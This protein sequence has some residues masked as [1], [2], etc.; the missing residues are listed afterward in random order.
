M[1]LIRIPIKTLVSLENPT[2]YHWLMLNS[3]TITNLPQ[4]KI[5]TKFISVDTS[6]PE[7]PA[8]S[9]VE[10]YGMSLLQK[11]GNENNVKDCYNQYVFMGNYNPNYMR[12]EQ[13]LS[14]KLLE[15]KAVSYDE[16]I[17]S[18]I[19]FEKI[20]SKRPVVEYWQYKLLNAYR[21]LRQQA[22]AN[23]FLNMSNNLWDEYL[24]RLMMSVTQSKSRVQE[25][26][27]ENEIINSSTVIKG[28]LLRFDR[29][30]V[31][32]EA[33]SWKY[34]E[35][36]ALCKLGIPK[37]LRPSIWSELFGLAKTK[38][39]LDEEAKAAKYYYYIEKSR[40][41][42]SLVY[43][44]MEQDILD[45]TLTSKI[46]QSD[47]LLLH[48]ERATV[49]KIAKAYY[50]WCLDENSRK[51]GK[52]QTSYGYFKGVLHILQ[53]ISRV[54]DESETFW[55]I[56]GFARS[57][58]YFFEV[59]DVMKGSLAW[60]HKKLMLMISTIV[61]VRF[62]EIYKAILRYELPIEYYLADKLS[63]LLS[64]VFSTEILMRFYD[65]VALEA[66]SGSQTRSMWIIITG[67][68]FLLATNE[69][70]IRSA[71]SSEE[72]E[73]IINNTGI[74]CLH[75]Q[76]IIEK[77]Y[78]LSNELFSFYNPT[79]EA[80]LYVL[81]SN[82]ETAVGA[83]YAW[84]Q[85]CRELD[86]RYQKVKELNGK[87]DEI[88]NRLRF[89]G[90]E[91]EKKGEETDCIKMFVGHFCSFYNSNMSKEV[92]STIFIYFSKAYNL[93]SEVPFINIAHG[94][95]K[96]NLDM[97][98]DGTIDQVVE[99]QA[100][101]L[102]NIIYIS[103]Q[104]KGFYEHM[105]DLREFA[106]DIPITLNKTLI[107]CEEDTLCQA[108]TPQ[109]F[110]SFVILITT[111]QEGSVDD[112]FKSLKQ[113]LATKS[114][115]ILPKRKETKQK[116]MLDSVV[117]TK[118]KLNSLYNEAGMQSISEEDKPLDPKNDMLALQ[119]FFALVQKDISEESALRNPEFTALVE[120][121]YD[122]L[123]SYNCKKVPLRRFV[124]S[125]ITASELTVEEKAGFYY[126]IY[127][128]MSGG[129]F[130]FLLDELIELIQLLYELH[131]TPIPLERIPAI[132]EA[133]MTD[134]GIN[135]ITNAYLLSKNV[136][137]SEELMKI[138]RSEEDKDSLKILVVTAMVQREFMKFCDLS[139]QRQVFAG[140]ELSLFGN[141]NKILGG[142]IARPKNGG[143]YTLVI[144][145]KYKGN[146]TYKT[147]SYDEKEILICWNSKEAP[148]KLFSLLKSNSQNLSFAG[149]RLKLTKDD[150]ITRFKKLP[151]L[152][153]IMRMNI[154][155]TGKLK[156]K[157]KTDLILEVIHENKAIVTIDFD[158]NM[159]NEPIETQRPSH[160]TITQDAPNEE[161]L[162]FYSKDGRF[163]I[164]LPAAHKEDLLAEIK[165]RTLE[166]IQKMT[167]II[168]QTDP[169][170]TIPPALD[171]NIYL[172]NS[173]QFFSETTP[174][175]DY[176]RLSR[177]VLFKTYNF[178]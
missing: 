27:K 138:H 132:V 9:P 119:H 78:Q 115:I 17:L 100:S 1:T 121:T 102:D 82:S 72:I 152:S 54:Y 112:A 55:C 8:S 174:F 167:S 92:P 96:E 76:K 134:E 11:A 73:L 68:I 149:E 49:L 26:A 3:A 75:A 6:A 130:P 30:R 28:S 86:I 44:Q 163:F 70:Y 24:A 87:V 64:T 158:S 106:T 141:L 71:R 13:D 161:N 143:P 117:N 173:L 4:I 42:D 31:W 45:I 104:G 47:S 126:D 151:L 91:E 147:F 93:D 85:K 79:F 10:G 18:R 176:T 50:A 128:S 40:L 38:G 34:S 21:Y 136:D 67:C 57:L 25:S 172:N 83:E 109:P 145:F 101:S 178:L 140:D 94:D 52:K 20:N 103:A 157:T 137:I 39:F 36:V 127:T 177:I 171:P 154:S 60:S 160:L 164:S 69:V 22:R 159:A 15:N 62:K 175:D 155:L 14:A 105:L 23:V 35:L 46:N 43:N 61:E 165:T 51:Y 95:Q 88:I 53:K 56:I 84:T 41:Q 2:K 139:G 135:K 162:K 166:A 90:Q 113:S 80:L 120:K 48:N 19:L 153:E 114:Q 125:L 148:N 133:V 99:L 66:A 150:F 131:V 65:L 98:S 142:Y 12:V 89:I 122:M 37:E 5:W 169:K 107:S 7:P 144:C 118:K 111:K 97:I 58:P 16:Q 124:I 146:V 108:T 168:L 170:A 77:V 33:G 32:K 129:G 116:E 59:Q 74:N 81:T 29:L 156:T 110:I 123:A 63:N